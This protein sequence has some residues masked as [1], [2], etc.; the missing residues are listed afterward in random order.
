M[1]DFFENKTI[2]EDFGES[3]D[4]SLPCDEKSEF[5][6]KNDALVK[7]KKNFNDL[8]E[9]V[10]QT[11]KREFKIKKNKHH[12]RGNSVLN[13]GT[14]P[15]SINLFKMA[16]KTVIENNSD[17]ITPKDD[18]KV[19]SVRMALKKF[20]FPPADQTLKNFSEII[21]TKPTFAKEENQNPQLCH[22]TPAIERKKITVDQTQ[23]RPVPKHAMNIFNNRSSNNSVSTRGNEVYREPSKNTNSQVRKAL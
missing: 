18:E 16:K 11:Q 12:H 5:S 2:K 22:K 17:S 10:A 14:M 21:T 3:N 1:S 15:K 6:I 23:V 8:K 7:A 19:N 4:V 13:A 9:S 20:E